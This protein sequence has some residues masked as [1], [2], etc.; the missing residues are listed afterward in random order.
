LLASGSITALGQ[1]APTPLIVFVCEHGSAKSLAALSFFERSAKEQGLAIRA[2]S[3]GTAP[4]AAVPPAVVGWLGQDGFSV[5]AFK[6]Q[7]LTQADVASATRVVAIGVDI[8]PLAA[9]A[10]SRLEKWND[11]PPFSE[12]YQRAREVMLSRVRALVGELA[13]GPARP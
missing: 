5:A 3:R 10:G 2:V 9:S 7:A 12:N 1:P 8:G 6:P 13:G 11:I 4:D